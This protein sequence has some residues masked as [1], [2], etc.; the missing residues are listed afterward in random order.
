MS[1]SA[2]ASEKISAAS[3]SERDQYRSRY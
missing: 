1:T 3:G 2:T